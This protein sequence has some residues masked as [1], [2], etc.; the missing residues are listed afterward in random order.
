MRDLSN[1]SVPT[2][3]PNGSPKGDIE[4][5]LTRV[6]EPLRM[7]IRNMGVFHPNERDFVTQPPGAWD[8]A[9]AEYHVRL[10]LLNSVLEELLYIE[11]KVDEQETFMEY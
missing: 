4:R 11:A 6:I 9:E 7:T 10:A 8:K 3:H 5:D 2:V 1:L